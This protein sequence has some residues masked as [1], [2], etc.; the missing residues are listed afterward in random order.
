M[1]T[2]PPRRHRGHPKH[3]QRSNRAAGPQD[4]PLRHSHPS[5]HA[6]RGH[7]A[8]SSRVLVEGPHPGGHAGH[9]QP[10]G[11]QPSA[12]LRLP[13]PWSTGRQQPRREQRQDQQQASAGSRG[14]MH[15][16]AAC[17]A[18]PLQSARSSRPRVSSTAEPA[19]SPAL[20]S[21]A[22]PLPVPAGPHS[23]KRPGGSSGG[24]RWRR[25][26]RPRQGASSRWTTGGARLPRGSWGLPTTPPTTIGWT[27]RTASR[28]TEVRCMSRHVAGTCRGRAVLGGLPLGAPPPPP[29]HTA[30]PRAPRCRR[31]HAL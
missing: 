28:A 10:C 2:T 21:V 19:A 29:A 24:A 14:A 26:R 23:S 25:P 9:W 1:H 7:K 20:I 6:A 16:A 31:L 27:C 4:T 22:S 12:G 30:L 3:I 17:A 5:P 18:M 15:G 13:T 11:R 8:S